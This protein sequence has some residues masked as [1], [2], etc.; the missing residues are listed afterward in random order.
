MAQNMRRAAYDPELEPLW[1]SDDETV[2][3]ELPTE[4]SAM[5][6]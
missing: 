5:M 6:S 3:L 2:P 1:P 4:L